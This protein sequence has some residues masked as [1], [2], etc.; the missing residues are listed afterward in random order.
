MQYITAARKAR[1]KD[2]W[3]VG[4][5]AGKTDRVSEITLD[6]L[7]KGKYVATIYCDAKDANYMTNPQAYTIYDKRVDNKTRLKLN[8]V[9]G[10]GYAIAIR[11]VKDDKKK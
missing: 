1:G 5:V 6:F 4:S 7:P 9:A 10:G 2:E 11:P 8:V 3:F